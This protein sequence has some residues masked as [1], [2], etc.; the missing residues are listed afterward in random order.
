MNCPEGYQ[1]IYGGLERTD[2][3]G[4]LGLISFGPN[5]NN[6]EQWRFRARR[7]SGMFEGARHVVCLLVQEPP[8]PTSEQ[9]ERDVASTIRTSTLLLD[10]TNIVGQAGCP[11]GFAAIGGGLIPD[12]PISDEDSDLRF[13]TFGPTFGSDGWRVNA[14][15]QR[16]GD[17]EGTLSV[18][19][20]LLAGV[21]PPDWRIVSDTFSCTSDSCSATGYC[22]DGFLPIS[23]GFRQTALS[24]GERVVIRDFHPIFDGTGNGWFFDF[25]DEPDISDGPLFNYG[26]TTTS[27]A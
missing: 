24:G 22:P 25:D 23:G 21:C 7:V 17:W 18:D 4:E 12:S 19:C 5:P 20:L 13:R 11:G 8:S 6:R 9:P 2:L 15:S 26:G 27:F 3:N 16:Q 14:Q 10:D 1:A